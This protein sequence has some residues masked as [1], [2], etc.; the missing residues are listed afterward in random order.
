M[1]RLWLIGVRQQNRVNER[2]DYAARR[3]NAL[4]RTSENLKFEIGEG[5]FSLTD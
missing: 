2:R 5:R 4:E 1:F 3:G